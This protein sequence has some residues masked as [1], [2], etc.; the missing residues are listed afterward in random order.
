MK[1]QLKQG[2]RPHISWINIYPQITDFCEKI[3]DDTF[4]NIFNN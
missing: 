1:E 3:Y 2:R 4:D